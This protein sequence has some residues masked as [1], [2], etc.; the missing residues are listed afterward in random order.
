MGF[1]SDLFGDE[2][3]RDAALRRA[4]KKFERQMS[5]YMSQFEASMLGI[6]DDVEAAQSVD[7]GELKAAF[8]Q[9]K[10]DFD[11]LVAANVAEGFE[12][13][14]AK[15]TESFG[16]ELEDIEL[17]TEGATLRATAQGALSGLG[18]TSFGSAQIE[19]YRQ[20]G[21]REQRRAKEDF[22]GKEMSLALSKGAAL[23]DVGRQRVDLIGQQARSLS[24]T[25][26]A[27]T[28][29]ISG[30]GSQMATGLLGAGQ[31]MAQGSADF[32]IARAENI[33]TGF[34]LGGA[35]LSGAAKGLGGGLADFGLKELGI[36][37]E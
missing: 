23:A 13:A 29:A 33:G 4:Q 5:Q 3:D 20:E 30:L 24:D 1:M 2:G 37:G 9:Q 34:N 18:M 10:S 15:L 11:N 14:E 27:Y 25:R 26:R 16:Q 7:I 36:G 8:E 32:G 31:S 22:A 17:A 19:A 21:L 6:I 28:V 35:I 12:R